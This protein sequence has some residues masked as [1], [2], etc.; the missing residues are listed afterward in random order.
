[1]SLM[2]TLGL[3]LLR[4]RSPHLP[5]PFKVWL[6]IA[7]L[8]L[9][10]QV[11]LIVTPFIRPVGGKGDTSLPYW[12]APLVSVLFMAGGVMGWF[13]WRVVWPGLGGFEWVGEEAV[14]G[15]GSVVRTWGK[16]KVV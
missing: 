7:I 5:R 2:V 10:A 12:L 11:F 16:M 1:M 4:R 14:L 6:P 8:F 9:L 15:D 13:V 3:F